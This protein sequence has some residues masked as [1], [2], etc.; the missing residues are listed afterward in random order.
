[1]SPC[2]P[3]ATD[4]DPAD[5]AAPGPD[6]G[7][8]ALDGSFDHLIPA[9]TEVTAGTGRFVVDPTVEV[10][11]VDPDA[12]VAA[13]LLQEELARSTGVSLTVREDPPAD[14]SG[15]PDTGRTIRFRAVEPT[16]GGVASG[17]T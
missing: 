17:P 3:E 9:P 6:P 10:V 16:P 8:A 4:D 15:A 14:A 7:A 13:C 1:T 11:V 2:G 5:P 12:V